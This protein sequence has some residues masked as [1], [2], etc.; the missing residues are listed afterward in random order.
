LTE[1]AAS[2]QGKASKPSRRTRTREPTGSAPERSSSFG[3]IGNRL[4]RVKNN[5]A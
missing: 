3:A 5:D 4:R 2:P 1:E